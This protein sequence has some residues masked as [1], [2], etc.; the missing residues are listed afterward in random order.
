MEFRAYSLPLQSHLVRALSVLETAMDWS[1]AREHL[2]A[3]GNHRTAHLVK[4]VVPPKPS[5]PSMDIVSPAGLTGLEDMCNQALVDPTYV[6]DSLQE[7]PLQ[8]SA[9]FLLLE[10]WSR[11]PVYLPWGV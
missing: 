11:L 9:I 8:W 1:R 3:R 10:S 6:S 5:T 7:Y 2:E 4:K